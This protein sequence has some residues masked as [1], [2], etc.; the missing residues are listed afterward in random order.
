MYPID[1]PFSLIH[2]LKE[3]FPFDCR[4]FFFS[5]SVGYTIA[6]NTSG[7]ELTKLAICL[8]NKPILARMEFIVF[9]IP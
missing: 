2:F 9:S 6:V 8:Q 5:I 7:D 4:R 3:Q 1:N